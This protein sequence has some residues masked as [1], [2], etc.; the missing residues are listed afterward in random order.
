MPPLATQAE[1]VTVSHTSLAA[2]TSATLRNPQNTKLGSLDHAKTYIFDDDVYPRPLAEGAGPWHLL[3]GFLQERWKARRPKARVT[4]LSMVYIKSHFIVQVLWIRFIID[5]GIPNEDYISI[6]ILGA[7]YLLS[8]ALKHKLDIVVMDK[9]GRSG[10]RKDLRNWLLQKILWLD[11]ETRLAFSDMQLTNTVMNEVEEAVANGWWQ[12]FLFIGAAS[13]M[14]ISI[15]TALVL[16]PFSL[17]PVVCALPFTLWALKARQGTNMRYIQERQDAEDSW[18]AEFS[19][20]I[21]NWRVIQVTTNRWWPLTAGRWPLAGA[22]PT[23]A[24]DC[25]RVIA[26]HRPTG[27]WITLQASL[28]RSTNTS[29]RCTAATASTSSTPCGSTSG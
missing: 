11:E 8:L 2:P 18:L 14:L 9:R 6:A 25:R 16:E 27:T 12:L 19:D 29:T 10:T 4:A 21:G 1:L 23:L 24:T 17:V 28:R 3:L 5:I 20:A 13:A 7:I 15:I 22:C 26:Q